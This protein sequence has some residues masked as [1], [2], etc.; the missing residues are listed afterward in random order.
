MKKSTILLF[1]SIVTPLFLFAQH[2]PMSFT[3][4]SVSRDVP[5]VTMPVLDVATL[6]A[7]DE[8]N[9]AG[10]LAPYKFGENID[11]DLN[12][13][14]SGNWESLKKGR[15]W[16]LAIHS[17][18]SFSLNFI[19]D[20]FFIPEGATL[21]LYGQDNTQI[22]GP[23][24]HQ[25]NNQDR[26]FGTFPIPNDIVY[27]E[28]YEPF[29]VFGLGALSIGSVTHAY[30]DLFA[31]YDSSRGG[32][33][34]SGACNNN[35][36]CPVGDDW[37]DDKRSVAIIIVGGSGSC[38]GAMVNNTAEDGTPYFLTAD[39]CL[40]GNT[41]NWSFKFDYEST[42]CT[43]AGAPNLNSG[44]ITSGATIRASNGGSD[45]G[46]LELNSTPPASHNVYYAGWDNSGTNPTNQVA[47]HHPSGDI[48]KISFDT[49]AATTANW[50]GAATW[51]ISDW[52]DGTTEPGSSGSP[53]FDENHKIIGQL[54]GGTA[55]CSNNIDD[56]YGRFDVSWDGSSSSSRLRDWLD[57]G[58]TGIATLDGWD[59]N[60]PTV[61]VDAGAQSVAGVENNATVCNTEV[62]LILTLKNSGQDNLTACTI[63]WE[64]DNVAQ[65]PVLWTGNLS[66]N[67]TD[68]ITFPTQNFT[69]GAHSVEF[70]IVSANNGADLNN[71][72]DDLTV[73]FTIVDG[74]EITVTI[75][76]DDYGNETT[77]E[78]EDSQGNVVVS[79]TGYDDN[80]QYTIP[81]CLADG[82]YTF[83]IYDYY[84]D[85]IC[86]GQYGDGAYE[87]LSP[88]GDL[89]GEGGEFEDEESI[90]FC[91]PF[92]VAPPVSVFVAPNT[93]LCIGESIT[94]V[95]N[96]TPATGVTYAWTFEGGS[97][98]SSSA[99]S[100]S[101]T[102]NTAGTFDVQLTVSNSAG[103][104]TSTQDNY[105][106]V[107]P[108]PSA[109]T[110][111]TGENLWTGGNNGT[112]TVVVTG[113]T[114]P[115]TYSWSNG[116][117]SD[118]TATGLDAGNY[119]VTVT[120]DN[121]CEAQSTVSVGSN[122]GINDL[123]LAE[124]INLYPNPTSG[125]VFADLPSELDIIDVTITDMVGRQISKVNVV[126]RTRV[127][128]DFSFYTEGVYHMN[129]YTSESK[130]TKK[131]VHLR[132]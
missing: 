42:G 79:G 34:G 3:K 21:H 55:N 98:A 116:G 101:I 88:N 84:G 58:N 115:Y 100:P 109:S 24:T 28:Y 56:Y 75:L 7:E 40:G 118:A 77:W 122:V 95:N 94:Y 87:L 86:C 82:C 12:L 68:D 123:E 103:T 4:A 60:Q 39:H 22:L 20:D 73:N 48:K 110:S 126:G 102:Y 27:L 71:S 45:F 5:M 15:L 70:M 19:F 121:G 9:M 2:V 14:N 1:F 44:F 52:E 76:T 62:N 67:E 117:G 89:M 129:F 63:N 17:E 93:D 51:H 131:V 72:N 85:G 90:E 128:L 130:A 114:P 26:T 18:A 25:N 105:V 80:T 96:S 112:A 97:P 49:D 119:T 32:L 99:Q 66:T 11:V 108:S 53:L 83:T 6:M 61:T 8:I 37:Q 107:A 111:S 113:G 33:G 47:I 29:D 30:R 36:N 50:G 57:P 16:R 41:N 120:D 65:P 59:P 43:N 35:V 127:S 124:A 91:L 38:T 125:V 54:Y 132:K 10:K 92:I 23:Y 13:N 106:N 46:L 104:N 74:E 64:V 69:P 31:Y 81:N 78:V